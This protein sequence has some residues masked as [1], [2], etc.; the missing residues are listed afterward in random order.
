VDVS[1]KPGKVPGNNVLKIIE[2]QHEAVTVIDCEGTI[3]LGTGSDLLRDVMREKGS[4]AGAAILLN[5]AGVSYFDQA[6]TGE[7]VSRF[8]A[9]T[10]RGGRVALLN[11]PEQ[12]KELFRFTRLG[13]V[14]AFDNEE[15]AVR[16]FG[17]AGSTAA[18]YRAA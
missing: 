16:S 8:T 18:R 9:V 5:L 12:L 7:L 2:R 3:E 14:P 4:N 17:L 6:G 13:M 10:N 15:D 1:V 11:V